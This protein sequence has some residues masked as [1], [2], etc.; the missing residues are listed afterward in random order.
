[1]PSVVRGRSTTNMTKPTHA[2]AQS[3]QSNKDKGF[4]F[5]EAGCRVAI[6]LIFHPRDTRKNAAFATL[7]R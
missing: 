1:M 6:L 3:S 7:V 4:I 5:R 2:K